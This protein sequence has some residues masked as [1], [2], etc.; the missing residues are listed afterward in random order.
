MF[1]A[2]V[3]SAWILLNGEISERHSPNTWIRKY[4]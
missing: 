3:E 4:S 1:W 2:I